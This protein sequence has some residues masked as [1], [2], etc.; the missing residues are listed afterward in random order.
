MFRINTEGH[1]NTLILIRRSEY[2]KKE[3]HYQE[4]SLNKERRAVFSLRENSSPA[5][6]GRSPFAPVGRKRKKKE[7]K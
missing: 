6:A 4:N 7:Q 5:L 1:Y 3:C 2:E